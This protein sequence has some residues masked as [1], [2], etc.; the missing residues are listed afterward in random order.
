MILRNLSL[1]IGRDKR[2]EKEINVLPSWIECVCV[3]VGGVREKKSFN[4][5]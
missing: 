5:L 4:T 1:R 3:C 2:T